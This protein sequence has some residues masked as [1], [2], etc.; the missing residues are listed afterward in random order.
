[1]LKV[2]LNR[3]DWNGTPA[4][5]RY[6]D[7]VVRCLTKAGCSKFSEQYAGVLADSENDFRRLFIDIGEGPKGAQIVPIKIKSPE[8]SPVS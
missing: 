2:K 7:T 4:R 8:P 6:H 3:L 5:D 1:M